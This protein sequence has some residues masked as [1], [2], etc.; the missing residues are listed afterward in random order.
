MT[1]V[2]NS[3]TLNLLSKRKR[4]FL[5]LA[6]GGVIALIVA[7][8]AYT[9]WAFY[10]Y[11]T[12]CIVPVEGVWNSQESGM[13]L[14][15][16][17]GQTVPG[18]Q[19]GDLLIA[20]DNKPLPRRLAYTKNIYTPLY[21][22]CQSPVALTIMRDGQ[23]YTVATNHTVLADSS[24]RYAQ[25][26]GQNQSSLVL[27]WVSLETLWM[28]SHTII[29]L[30]VG[31]NRRDQGMALFTSMAMMLILTRAGVFE[32]LRFYPP[33]EMP[34]HVLIAF[35]TAMM[36][37]LLVFPTGR[38]QPRFFSMAY[39][40]V[41][42]FFILN[43]FI[44]VVDFLNR[45]YYAIDV[46][47]LVVALLV[48]V[49][50]YQNYYSLPQRQQTKWV[51]ALVGPT[52]LGY[53]LLFAL[54]Y[55]FQLNNDVSLL[56]T[57]TFGRSFA[58]IGLVG[59]LIGVIGYRLYNADLVLNRNIV[60]GGLA[61]AFSAIFFV[62]S[63]I[64]Q[65]FLPNS[66]ARL[67]AFIGGALL[68]ATIFQPARKTIQ[69]FVD[70]RFFRLRQDLQTLEAKNA[71]R[72]MERPSLGKGT[73]TGKTLNQVHLLD[74]LGVG[75]MGEVYHGQLGI[76]KLAVK[77]IPPAMID[78]PEVIGR[79]QQ[80]MNILGDI[81]HPNVVHLIDKGNANGTPY[82]AMEY[83]TGQT[84][85]HYLD[86]YNALPLN[87]TRLILKDIAAALDYVHSLGIIHRDVKPA[88]IILQDI[89][90]ILIDFGLAISLKK[91]ELQNAEVIGTLDY[92]APEQILSTGKITQQADVYALG[93]VAYKMLTGHPPFKGNVSQIVFAHLNQPAQNPCA[94]APDLPGPAGVAILRALAKQPEERFTSAGEF[95]AALG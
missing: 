62:F 79:F 85:S 71:Q 89:R 86:Q 49:Y 56:L 59:V 64:A 88:N 40:V 61:I 67:I 19:N 72:Q 58:V 31:W 48:Q 37:F 87:Q 4:K 30:W 21:G 65:I 36:S 81:S 95:V 41:Y 2:E 11:L 77:V 66:Y 84:L 3:S 90:A 18:V 92:A 25:E 35:Q 28:L 26:N 70:K 47:F 1:Y 69:A 32:Q 34:M 68:F 93:A 74:V 57:N 51:I 20:I 45:N 5:V 39:L 94:L 50:R 76:Q 16:L 73:F 42:A 46:L 9:V 44:P 78:K 8:K 63:L 10:Q 17:P 12:F 27:L 55:L 6:W 80:E 33:Y 23:S 14:S 53:T 82:F 7:S 83:V 15:L 60:Y 38:L 13:K 29:C 52:I 22:P 24:M 75:G 43:R 91:D 54:A